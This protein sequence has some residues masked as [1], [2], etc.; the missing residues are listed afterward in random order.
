MELLI[1]LAI[2]AL[3]GGGTE[4]GGSMPWQ[5]PDRKG[6]DELRALCKR[7]GLSEMHTAFLAFVARGESGWNN[8][9]GLGIPEQFPP[10]TK[11]TRNAGAAGRNEA[12]AARA[13]YRQN[14]GKFASCP[15]PDA[16]YGFGSGGWFGFLPAYGL[17]QFP[18]ASG[19]RCLSP[20]A[21]FDPVAS[22]CMA[23]GFARGLQGWQGFKK[24]PTVLNLR[25]MWGRP[26]KGGDAD[27]IAKRRAHYTK[28]LTGMGLPASFADEVI[29]RFP[30]VD[31]GALYRQLGGTPL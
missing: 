17:A 15:W 20:A 25:L 31:L 10:G 26:A 7:A 27:R 6:L 29:P 4:G 23:I 5:P 19:L 2:V 14:A 12:R 24:V 18:K 11:P 9:R 28:Q 8:L 3:V 13:A 21:V 30:A 1:L 22:V 16:A